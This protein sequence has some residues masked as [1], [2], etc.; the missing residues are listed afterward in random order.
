MIIARGK[1]HLSVY[2]MQEKLSKGEVNTIEKEVSTELWHKHLDHMSEKRM[3]ILVKKSLLP[4][5]KGTSL[6]TC[7]HC[8]TSNQHRLPCNRILAS[9]KTI[10][11]DLVHSDVCGP[12]T[13]STFGGACYFVTFIDDHSRK[14]WAYG[15]R[16]KDG[17]L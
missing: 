16:T 3:Q 4:E 1:K 8:L 12:M 10:V 13:V 17:V 9:R 5:V 14:A 11:L 2:M 7:V 15:L 6:D